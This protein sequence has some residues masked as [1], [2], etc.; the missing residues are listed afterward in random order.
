[1]G[2]GVWRGPG[3]LSPTERSIR[4]RIGAHELHSRHDSHELT[5]RGRAAAATALNVKLLAEI[6]PDN[7]LT[8][9]ER[10]RRLYH[11][12]KAHFS[13]L[14]LKSAKARRKGDAK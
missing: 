1:M 8:V 4:A 6:D 9:R 3:M 14:A 2:D 10:E 5:A 7:S 11:A 12:R 13:K